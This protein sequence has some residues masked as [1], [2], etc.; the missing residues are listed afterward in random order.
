MTTTSIV[1]KGDVLNCPR[2]RSSGRR[3]NSDNGA[4]ALWAGVRLAARGAR[5]TAVLASEPDRA[6]LNAF[7]AADG[8]VESAL[9]PGGLVGIGGR[10]P[11]RAAAAALAAHVAQPRHRCGRAALTVTFGTYKPGL[12]LG[13]G[14]THAGRVELVDIGLEPWLDSAPA[15]AG[16]R[17]DRPAHGRRDRPRLASTPPAHRSSP[18]SAPATC[19]TGPS[20][21]FWHRGSQRVTPVR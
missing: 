21:R 4:D 13:V 6:G 16:T 19:W 18:P 15:G 17:R 12:L 20:D 14:R 9:P 10:G 2:Y 8:R 7:L 11:L 3:H 1:R 5:V